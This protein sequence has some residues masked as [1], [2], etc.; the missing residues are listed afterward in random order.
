MR[1]LFVMALV[2]LGMSGL[3]CIPASKSWVQSY[4]NETVSANMRQTNSE[5]QALKDSI[6]TLKG[7]VSSLN[8]RVA[9]LESRM[10]AVDSLS[11]TVDRLQVRID[12]I[13]NYISNIPA[14]PSEGGIEAL[15][16][17]K[18]VIDEYITRVVDSLRTV[19]SESDSTDSIAQTPPDTTGAQQ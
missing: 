7:Q 11:V 17:L 13:Q 3:S 5:I 2:A 12:S 8:Q 9:S 16:T 15:I 14:V 18:N 6:A 10:A 4:V 19:E 1:S